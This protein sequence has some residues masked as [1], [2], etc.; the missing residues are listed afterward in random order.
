MQF[1]YE[2]CCIFCSNFTEICSW[3]PNQQ[4]AIIGLANDLAPTRDY[5][6]P[7]ILNV[8]LKYPAGEI[9]QHTDIRAKQSPVT[10]IFPDSK[11][12]G[13]NMGPTWVLSAPGGPHEPCYLGCGTC[14]LQASHQVAVLGLNA[15]H[16]SVDAFLAYPTDVLGQDYHCIS[17]VDNNRQAQMGVVGVTDGTTV[18]VLLPSGLSDSVSFEG[19][20]YVAGDTITTTLDRYDSLQLTTMTSTLGFR[21]LSDHPVAAFSGNMKAK[22]I[23]LPRDHLVTQLIPVSAWGYDFAAIQI[24]RMATGDYFGIF[25]TMDDTVVT[26][27]EHNSAFTINAG[28]YFALQSP[29]NATNT[30]TSTAPVQVFNVPIGDDTDP[31]SFLD[32]TITPLP[33]LNQQLSSYIF[34]APEAPAFLPYDFLLLVIVPATETAGLYLDCQPITGVVWEPVADSNPA[35]VGARLQLDPGLHYIAHES[36]I[37]TFSAILYGYRDFETFAYPVGMSLRALVN[38]T[39]MVNSSPPPPWTKW[40]SF[41]RRYF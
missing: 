4:Y 25:A 21:I 17:S 22:V 15:V 34:V 40:L 39:L 5:F 26:A 30:I 28:E 36:P 23:N 20:T 11:V 18:K 38:I 7:D 37:V 3:W 32:G 24:P 6:W 31:S 35:L 9:L 1:M 14:I 19:N 12:H 16:T 13:A 8:T 10:C 27:S 33:P 41:C 2:N 29:A